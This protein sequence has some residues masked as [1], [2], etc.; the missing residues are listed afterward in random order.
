MVLLDCATMRKLG[1]TA[2]G[3]Y[4]IDPNSKG[5]MNV[6]CDMTTNGGGWTII[7]RRVNNSTDFYQDWPSY[8]QGFG[9]LTGNLWLGNDNIHRL[10]ASGN[11]VLQVELED[12]DGNTAYAVY[13]TFEVDDESNKYRL[14]VGGYSGTAGDSLGYYNERSFTTKDQDNDRKSGANC[15][16]VRTGA[17]WYN[18]CAWSNLNGKYLGNTVNWDGINWYHWKNNSLSLKRSV[19]MVRPSHFTLHPS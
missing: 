2:N 13:G 4:S 19:M 8:K 18:S 5:P 3:I 14:T 15:A 6:S 16:Q 9:T 17:W 10:T 1:V 12:W 11:T 7:Q